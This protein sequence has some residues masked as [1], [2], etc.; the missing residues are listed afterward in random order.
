MLLNLF[1]CKGR[2]TGSI[3]Q[4]RENQSQA[5][6]FE[7]N[8]VGT[9]KGEKTPL[10]KIRRISSRLND[11]PSRSFELIDF[12]DQ[13]EIHRL[14]WQKF[15]FNYVLKVKPDGRWKSSTVTVV[16]ARQNGESTIIEMSILGKLLERTAST[17][18]I[19]SRSHDP[20]WDLSP[21][22]KHH[23]GQ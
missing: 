4:K 12:A 16:A 19:D 17:P 10:S 11:L 14:P 20:A 5:Q 2:S 1:H 22:R 7:S 23:W 6:S 21:H 3:S 9:K 8:R 13:L 15:T 18:G